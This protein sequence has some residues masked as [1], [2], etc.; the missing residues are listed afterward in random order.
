MKTNQISSRECA[1]IIYGYVSI[2]TFLL[3]SISKLTDSLEK[4]MNFNS[5]AT[6]IIVLNMIVFLTSLFYKRKHIVHG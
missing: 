3:M 6:A 5:F 1:F 2:S 4:A